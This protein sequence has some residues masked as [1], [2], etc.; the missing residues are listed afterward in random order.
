MRTVGKMGWRLWDH[1][2]VYLPLFL[3]ALLALGTYW[4]VR[5][6]P[7]MG[8]VVTDATPTHDPDYFMRGFSVRSFGADGRLQSE[9]FGAE[10]RHYPDTDTLEIDQPRIRST[11]LRNQEARATADR[12]LTNGDA[13]EVQLIGN[14]RVVRDGG[15]DANGQTQLPMVFNSEYLH[16]FVNTEKIQSNKPV[17]LTRGADRFSA[18]RMEYDNSGRVL[19]LYG[20]VR[21]VLAP[22][23]PR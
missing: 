8:E 14:A 2:S 12:A 7:V 20:Q 6:A 16:V 23:K 15:K 17:T 3:M 5:N 9:V 1:L 19:Q 11:N 10:A 18:N 21:V 13:S 4:L 22:P